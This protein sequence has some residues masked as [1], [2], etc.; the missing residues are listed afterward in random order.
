MYNLFVDS[1]ANS[2]DGDSQ[3][4]AADRCLRDGE[5]TDSDL[6]ARYGSLSSDKIAELRR[7][8]CV[9]AYESGCNKDPK[10]GF[11]RDVRVLRGEVRIEYDLIPLD[12]FMTASELT[13]IQY[14]LDIGRFELNR[15]HWAV[16][17]VDLYR[18]LSSI[19][20]RLPSRPIDIDRR[21]FDVALSFPGQCRE[22]VRTIAENLDDILGHDKCFG[23]GSFATT[24]MF[25]TVHELDTVGRMWVRGFRHPMPLAEP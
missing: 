20:I 9:F 6:A 8:P 18:K 1:D 25:I 22:Y 13:E 14:S 7:Y 10:Y 11:L 16:K 24:S 4:F 19:G 5:G 17:K 3:K 15:T 12:R 2:W 21:Q 23:C